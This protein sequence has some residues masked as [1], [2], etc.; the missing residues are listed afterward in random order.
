VPGYDY[1]GI[2]RWTAGNTSA[3]PV[4]LFAYNY[5]LIPINIGR[6]HWTLI[7]ID[8]QERTITYLDSTRGDG[9]AIIGNVQQY[10][11]DE[12][13]H[14]KGS[15]LDQPYRVGVPPA[16]LPR[17]RNGFDCGAFVCAFGD[18]LCRG[19]WPSSV[20]FTQR[21]MDYWRR[22]IGVSCIKGEL[23]E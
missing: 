17:Q 1:P 7:Y 10:L 18:M 8:N 4:D 23:L 15:R 3:P 9:T 19:A 11:D 5:V 13:L 21:S 2:A 22:R 14:K 12:H 16:D 20:C 6:V